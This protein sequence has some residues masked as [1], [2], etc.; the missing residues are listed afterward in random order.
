MKPLVSVGMPVYNAEKTLRR[1]IE[2]VLAQDYEHFELIISD[3][4]STDATAEI[5]QAFARED[6][7]ISFV[8]QPTNKGTHWNFNYVVGRAKGQYF[9]RMSHD[10]VR[11]PSYLTKCVALLEANPQAV[12]CHSYMAA[13]YDEDLSDIAC[14]VTHDTL[15]GVQDPR[16]RFMCALR[17]FSAAAMDGVFRTDTLRARTRLLD[18][19]YFSSDLVLTRELML[20]GEFVQVPEVL[21][22]RFGKAILPPPQAVQA[23]DTPHAK[24]TLAFRLPFIFLFLNHLRSIRRSPLTRVDKAV[25]SLQ[26]IGYEC[27]MAIVKAGRSQQP[28]AT[29]ARSGFSGVRLP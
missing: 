28:L 7:R 15:I 18:E 11:A 2:S 6:A 17:Y 19:S 29:G 1:A 8:R 27:K 13:F 4:A 22:W 9:V 23:K 16:E 21:F 25:L 24:M 3:N 20:H 26:V 14:I 10:D 5:C 12:M